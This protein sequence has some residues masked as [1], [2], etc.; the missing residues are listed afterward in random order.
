MET[1]SWRKL[2]HEAVHFLVPDVCM[3]CGRVLVD[4]QN[5]HPETR[6]WGVCLSC[7]STM[8][9][10]VCRERWFPCL[11]DPYDSDPIKDFRVW[12]LMLYERPVTGLLRR[13][14]FNSS[15]YCGDFLGTLMGQELKHDLD[16]PADAVIPVP[17]SATRK[18]AR[19]YNQAAVLGEKIAE[20]L[21]IPLLEEVLVRVRHTRAQSHLSG[22]YARIK[23]LD[24]AFAVEKDWDIT[25]WTILLVDDI[26]T[27]GS[28]LHEAARVLYAQGAG[29]VVGLVAASHRL[30]KNS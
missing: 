9:V 7:M 20:S 1:K 3:I 16:F 24:G 5:S 23:N 4:G 29:S 12:V 25:G 11:S 21:D 2:L 10:R 30:F 19:G 13:L 8:P 22:P 6:S 27:T 26:L 18:K 14:K 15:R 17:L 28:T